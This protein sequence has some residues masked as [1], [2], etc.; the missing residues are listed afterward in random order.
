MQIL[1]ID[2]GKYKSVACV[3]TVETGEASYVTLGTRPTELRELFESVNADRIVIEVCGIAG[4][5]CDLGESMARWVEVVDTRDERWSW[6]RVKRKTDRRDAHKIAL[7]A[8]RNEI[9]RVHIPKRSVRQWRSMIKYRHTLMDR[10][11]AVKNTI[12]ALV[13]VQG[14]Q[15]R[16]GSSGWTLESMTRLRELSKETAACDQG[17]LWRGQLCIELALL[18]QLTKSIDE[19]DRRLNK[20][21]RSSDQARLVSS[22]PGV[23]P[24]TAE[25][26]VTALDDARRFPSSREVGAY[27]GLVPRQ[28][29]SGMM[30]RSGRI[31]KQGSALL[32]RLLVQA[33][34]RATR[35]SGRVSAQFERL[36]GGQRSRRKKAIVAIA[37]RLLIWCWAMLRDGRP[38]QEEPAMAS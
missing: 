17:E 33:A 18:E 9:N 7:M 20:L 26:I 16:R 1:A 32:R 23:G 25:M 13:D 24:R 36:T 29:E 11:T 15:M 38:W 12:R 5:I 31:D 2:L 4:W 6:K 10:R 14:L 34:W 27:A 3:Y 19:L 21:A 28:F 22:A 37:R 35:A 8:S 30:K